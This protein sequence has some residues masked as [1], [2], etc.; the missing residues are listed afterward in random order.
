MWNNAFPEDQRESVVRGAV[1]GAEMRARHTAW[2]VTMATTVCIPKITTHTYSLAV[3]LLQKGRKKTAICCC[4]WQL[5]NLMG[6]NIYFFNSK[7]NEATS[8]LRV[9]QKK[10]YYLGL[11]HFGSIHSLSVPLLSRSR[12]GRNFSVKL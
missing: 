4:F 6:K 5:C 12:A 10:I 2:C 3:T 11:N 9:F 8:P 1:R 7:L